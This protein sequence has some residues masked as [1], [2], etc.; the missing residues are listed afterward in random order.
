M[1][2]HQRRGRSPER[3]RRSTRIGIATLI[4]LAIL[5]VAIVWGISSWAGGT[6]IGPSVI[7]PSNW[8]LL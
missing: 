5:V 1:S 6:E 2:V 3:V 7:G 8:L 4:L